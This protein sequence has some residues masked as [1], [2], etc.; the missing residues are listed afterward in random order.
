MWFKYEDTFWIE[1]RKIGRGIAEKL[2]FLVITCFMYEFRV[3]AI[4]LD[5]S[6]IWQ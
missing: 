6:R 3:L 2:I 5:E 1:A 4:S